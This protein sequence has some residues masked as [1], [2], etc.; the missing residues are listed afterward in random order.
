M[1]T[2]TERLHD[3]DGYE[4]EFPIFTA[5]TVARKTEGWGGVTVG[6]F[7]QDTKDGAKQLL[8]TYNRNYSTNYNNFAPTRKGD[9]YFAL[10][11]PDYTCTRVMEIMPGVGF[12]DIGGEEGD[13]NGFCPVDLY[14]PTLREY[15]NEQFDG[16]SSKIKDWSR[17]LDFFPAGSRMTEASSKSKGRQKLE[18]PDGKPIRAYTGVMEKIGPN[19]PE[20]EKYKSVWGPERDDFKS[21]FVILPPSHA[22]VAGCYW[23]DDG[24]WKIQYIDV[25][26]ID[27]GIIKR[28]ERFGY[29]ELPTNLSLKKAIV[30]DDLAEIGRIRMSIELDFDLPTGA[31]M[32]WSNS[33]TKKLAEGTTLVE[34]HHERNRKF[35]H[36]ELDA[37]L[38]RRWTEQGEKIT[39]DVI[40]QGG[41]IR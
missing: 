18:Y 1:E 29:I 14:I 16:G 31:A 25:S 21:G 8:G 5:E 4:F 23:G 10:Y 15:V 38:K 24:S 34:A 28:E 33:L 2:S 22:F 6:V 19:Y 9:R 27:E 17:I 26:R 36:K 41:E 13:S 7:Q 12:K 40:S 3:E 39:A 32:V 30:V 35:D 11:S 37:E 20:R